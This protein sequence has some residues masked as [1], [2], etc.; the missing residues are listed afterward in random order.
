MKSR[1]RMTPTHRMI[2]LKFLPLW[3]VIEKEI[4]ELIDNQDIKVTTFKDLVV[5]RL[6]EKVISYIKVKHKRLWDIELKI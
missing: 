5:A 6:I 3:D 4:E 2:Y 1:K